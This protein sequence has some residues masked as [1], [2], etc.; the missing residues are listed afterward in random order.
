MALWFCFLFP[1]F[2]QSCKVLLASSGLSICPSLHKEGRRGSYQFAPSG[3]FLSLLFLLCFQSTQGIDTATLDVVLVQEASRVTQWPTRC[4]HKTLRRGSVQGRSI[5][6]STL[7]HTLAN[8]QAFLF[9]GHYGPSL[10][11]CPIRCSQ[12]SLRQ[13]PLLD[14][15]SEDPFNPASCIAHIVFMFLYCVSH[16][17]QAHGL[18]KSQNRSCCCPETYD[19]WATSWLKINVFFFFSIHHQHFDSAF[20]VQSA[21]HIC[22]LVVFTTM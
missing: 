10:K 8:P 19:L 4:S 1:C 2:S 3:P 14:R 5:Q 7:Y 15:T 12:I 6:T 21:S 9:S 11:S 18:E 22:Y 16:N 17:G 20:G 13:A